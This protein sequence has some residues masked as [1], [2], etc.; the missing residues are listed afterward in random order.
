MAQQYRRYAPNPQYNPL[1]AVDNAGKAA[2]AAR[3]EIQQMR[4]F[5]QSRRVVDQQIIEDTRFVGQDAQ[6]LA[7]LTKT[8]A[9]YFKQLAKQTAEDKEVGAT[10][11]AYNK[12]IEDHTV[13][14]ETQAEATAETQDN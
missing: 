5:Y 12:G 4:D 11:D 6:T 3:K 1:Y 14:T 10:W 8:G 13:L 9:D 7:S 2:D